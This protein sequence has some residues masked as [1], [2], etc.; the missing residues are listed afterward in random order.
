M[1]KGAV[2]TDES[3]RSWRGGGAAIPYCGEKIV[4]AP[5]QGRATSPSLR[6]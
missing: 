2:E 4:T 3:T 5:R 1:E 6:R